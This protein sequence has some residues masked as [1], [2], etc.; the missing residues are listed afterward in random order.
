MANPV[1]PATLPQDP[2]IGLT[3]EL[4]ADALVRT[5][6][7]AGPAKVRRRHG[8]AVRNVTVPLILTG[9]Q[10]QT[11]DTFYKTTLKNGSLQWDWKDP[12]DGAVISFR[13]VSAAQ[14]ILRKGGTTA[15]RLWEVAQGMA[16]EILP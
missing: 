1:W 8:A 3:D 12:V 10:R 6:M 15:T 11:Y 2:F 16:L 13:F 7:S 4:S 5:Q 9:A 14:F